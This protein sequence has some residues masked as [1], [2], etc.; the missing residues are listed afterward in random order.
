MINDKNISLV[1]FTGSTKVGRHVNERVSK[2]FGKV[3]LELGGNNCIIVDE[4]AD[5]DIAVPA[6]LKGLTLSQVKN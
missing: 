6:N 2:R 3:I 1:S 4:T 5:M